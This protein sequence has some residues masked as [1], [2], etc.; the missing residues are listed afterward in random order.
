[1]ARHIRELIE[2]QTHP[3]KITKLIDFCFSRGC[4]FIW[5][6]R[7]HSFGTENERMT[8]WI[9]AEDKL[10]EIN[11][12]SCVVLGLVFPSWHDRHI[13]LG[14]RRRKW[15]DDRLERDRVHTQ[16]IN[17]ISCLVLGLV[18]PSGHDRHI[19]LGQRHRKWEDDR[20]ERDRGHTQRINEISCLVLGLAFPSGHDRHIYLGQKH[21]KREDDRLE[22]DRRHT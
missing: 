17:E 2:W 4:V 12:I 3:K 1:M 6:W 18:F 11:E 13:Y 21:R 22:R 19:Y 20:L 14:Q 16:R 9:E 8:D 10:K 7:T 15:E 5:A